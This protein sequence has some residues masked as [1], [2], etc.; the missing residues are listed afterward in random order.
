MTLKYFKVISLSPCTFLEFIYFA[1]FVSLHV[2]YSHVKP[3]WDKLIKK[4]YWRCSHS[5]FRGKTTFFFEARLH[6]HKRIN[7]TNKQS[8]T[9][10]TVVSH[11]HVG[12]AIELKV[13][14]YCC[15][16]GRAGFEHGLEWH[17][18]KNSHTRLS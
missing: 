3:N 12:I 1:R 13:H 7:I 4:G 17:V 15:W 2:R 14:L 9:F 8:R 6:I 16:H 10:I 5:S 11:K 18:P